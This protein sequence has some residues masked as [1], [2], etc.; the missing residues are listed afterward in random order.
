MSHIDDG[1]EDGRVPSVT[2]I[3][4]ILPEPAIPLFPSTPSSSIEVDRPG[5]SGRNEEPLAGSD[6]A[7]TASSVKSLTRRGQVL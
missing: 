2:F 3:A 7:F 1:R 5:G 4:P 6:H